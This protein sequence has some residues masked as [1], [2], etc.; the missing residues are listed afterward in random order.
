MAETAG[1]LGYWLVGQDGGV[2]TFGNAGFF[3][4]GADNMNAEPVSAIT[5]SPSGKGYWLVASDGYI[6]SYGDAAHHG[7]LSLP[8]ATSS[9]VAAVALAPGG[10][11]FLFA[12]SDGSMRSSG[13]A[14]IF[15]SAAGMKLEGAIVGIAYSS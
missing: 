4:S 1:G 3:G 10:E 2:F 7:S 12:Q 13:T 8:S 11:G 6:S 5:A 14:Q 15:G 9:A